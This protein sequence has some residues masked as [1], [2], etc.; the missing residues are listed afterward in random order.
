M[1][2]RPLYSAGETY[3]SNIA[4]Y[5]V[6]LLILVYIGRIQEL[7]LFLFS[8]KLGKVFMGMTILLYFLSPRKYRAQLTLGIPQVKYILGLL[9]L[10]ILSVPLS[11]YTRGSM[12]F[13]VFSYL[14]ILIFV[15][16]MVKVTNDTKDLRKINWAFVI[17]IILL[18]IMILTIKDPGRVSSSLTYDPNDF[19]AIMV[20]SLP[21]LYFMIKGE[22]GLRKGILFITIICMLYSIIR[23]AS[24]GGFIGLIFVVFLILLKDRQYKPI[25]KAAV[26]L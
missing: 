19:A 22:A 21:I 14:K 7:F 13:I 8:L 16:L 5:G 6:I 4:L 3:R 2:E 25:K 11:I 18:N 1:A 23:T 15:F 24:R 26:R 12:D 9:F 10:A 20:T 17:A